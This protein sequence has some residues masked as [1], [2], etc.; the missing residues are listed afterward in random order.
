MQDRWPNIINLVN[1]QPWVWRGRSEREE[2]NRRMFPLWRLDVLGALVFILFFNERSKGLGVFGIAPCTLKAVIQR[3]EACCP[4]DL[5]ELQLPSFL[6]IDHDCIRCISRIFYQSGMGNCW[7]F[8]C[9]CTTIPIIPHHWPCC[10]DLVGAGVQQHLKG[11]KLTIPA[12]IPGV[13]VRRW[14]LHAPLERQ[15]RLYMHVLRG[16]YIYLYSITQIY[17]IRLFQVPQVSETSHT[18]THTHRESSG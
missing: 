9:C 17:F 2:E 15:E 18:H 4:L 10:L 12:V 14:L 6:T 1:F 11:T 13:H 3:W 8:G 7:P 16:N 5:P